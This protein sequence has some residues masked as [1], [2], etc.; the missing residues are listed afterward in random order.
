MSIDDS[1]E[2]LSSREQARRR[3]V[4]AALERLREG[5]RSRN[6]DLSEHEAAALADRFSRELIESM[7]REKKITFAP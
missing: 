3:E 4:L 5:V 7:V 2:T 1:Q 6:A